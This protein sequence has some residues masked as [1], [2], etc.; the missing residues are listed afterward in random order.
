MSAMDEGSKL[1]FYEVISEANINAETWMITVCDGEHIGEKALISGGEISWYSDDDGFA[2]A[3]AGEILNIRES[4]LSVIDGCNVYSEL[5]GR[6]KKLVICGAGHVSMPI[7]TLGKMMGMHVTA[8]DDRLTFANNAI[9]Q[10]A[11][12][13]KFNEFE[14]A[15]S[16]IESDDDTYFVIVTRGHRYDKECLRSITKKPHAYIGMMGSRRRVKIVKE[17]LAAE[18]I[19]QDVLDSVYTPIGKKIGA[20]TPEEIA[21]AV[22]AEIIEVKNGKKRSFG[23]PQ[24]IMKALLSDEREAVTMATIIARQGSAP[25]GMGTKMLIGR[26]GNNVGTIGGGCIEGNVI[27]KGRRMLMEGDHKPVIVEVDMTCDA[28]ED[29][30]MVCGGRVRVLL[31]VV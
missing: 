25:R 21:V 3:H 14:A 8:I 28:A 27:A 9:A 31:E 2:R 4:G 22:M 23:L 16:E 12:E 19:P 18:G 30:G 10:G 29:E 1:S 6:D 24:D 13:V 11:D 26:D 17:D 7:I 15:L 5:L 20:E